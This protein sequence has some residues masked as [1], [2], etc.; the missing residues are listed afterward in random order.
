ME[1]YQVLGI[2]KAGHTSSMGFGNQSYC[3]EIGWE[4]TE[5]R[6][7]KA[8][9]PGRWPAT[10]GAQPCTRWTHARTNHKDLGALTLA[11]SRGGGSSDTDLTIYACSTS[12]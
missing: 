1:D 5:I 11:W 8:T 10:R 7:Q 6:N 2:Q 12:D 4:K 9:K 3:S